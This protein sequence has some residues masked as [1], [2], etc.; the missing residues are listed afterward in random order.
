[1]PAFFRI[2]QQQW[3]HDAMS[4]EGARIH[5][6]RWNPAGLPAVYLAES[7]AL[8]ALEI[9]VHAP[10]EM[11]QLDWAIIRVEVPAE[12]IE[13]SGAPPTGWRNHPV[14]DTA[15]KSGAA[16]L[17]ACQGVALRL[18]SVIIPQEYTLLVNPRHANVAQLVVSD[19]EVF[20]FDS[21]LGG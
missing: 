12:W 14:S 16:W 21:R 19:P 6:G 5:G 18:P 10:R 2:V 1:M 9:M 11:L 3:A 15:R 13:E 20:G 17:Q 8:A 7:R 4:G